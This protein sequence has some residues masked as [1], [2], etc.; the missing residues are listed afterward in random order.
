[1]S[2]SLCY[3]CNIHSSIHSFI[4]FFKCVLKQLLNVTFVSDP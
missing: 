2:K 4:Q 3:F 1:M